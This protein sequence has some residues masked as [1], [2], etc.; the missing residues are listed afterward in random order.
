MDKIRNRKNIYNTYVSSKVVFATASARNATPHACPLYASLFM[1]MH[2]LR[3][4]A[5]AVSTIAIDD[6]FRIMRNHAQKCGL[7]HYEKIHQ[8]GGLGQGSYRDEIIQLG[9]K[10]HPD[11]SPYQSFPPSHLSSTEPFFNSS[12]L[13]CATSDTSVMN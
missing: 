8:N 11:K 9:G 12:S 1:Q 6:P 3:E 13:Q 10:W 5:A 7:L 2:A 4:A